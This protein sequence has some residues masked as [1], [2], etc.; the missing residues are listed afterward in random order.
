MRLLATLVTGLSVMMANAIYP[1]DHF[2]YSTK[3]TNENHEKFISDNISAGKTVFLR[4][5]ASS[6]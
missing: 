2:E 3:L 6:G 5:I 4:T 1:E